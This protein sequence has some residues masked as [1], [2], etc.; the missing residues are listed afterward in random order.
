MPAENSLFP[1]DFHDEM[2]A[3][4]P[5]EDKVPDENLSAVN[6]S[7]PPAPSVNQRDGSIVFDIDPTINYEG[8]EAIIDR[9]LAM[10]DEPAIR[11]EE[12]VETPTLVET[13][14]RR[15]SF[16]EVVSDFYSRLKIVRPHSPS[17]FSGRVNSGD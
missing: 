6:W 10:V 4:H 12:I 5:P 8:Q 11:T 9:Y 3:N 16:K 14:S 7:E 2:W 17:L 13:T 1:H 15:T